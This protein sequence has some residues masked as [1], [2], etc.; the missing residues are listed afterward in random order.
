M[1]SSRSA[2]VQSVTGI[3]GSTATWTVPGLIVA[4]LR[5]PRMSVLRRTMG[6]TGTP[7]VMAMRK[8]PF[9][10]GRRSPVSDRVPSGA[11]TTEMPSRSRSVTGRMAS[12][13]PARSDLSIMAASRAHAI[14]APSGDL[15]ISFLPIP[16]VR[17]RTSLATTKES[18]LVRWLWMNTLGRAAHRFDAPTT[19]TL[20]LL[21]PSM[22]ST[23]IGKATSTPAR[24]SRLTKPTATPTAAAGIT[25]DVPAILRATCGSDRSPPRLDRCSTG[26]PRRAATLAR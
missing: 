17:S 5:E 14:R 21:R 24:R 8:A 4:A 25:L 2:T 15:V 9:L 23:H 10:K 11:T 20:T 22:M 26:Q 16:L 19:S 12:I 1:R 13:A 7:A 6:V 18:K 3:G